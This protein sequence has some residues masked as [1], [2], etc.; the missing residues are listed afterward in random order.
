MFKVAY[1][2]ERV[3]IRQRGY[4]YLSIS[5]LVNNTLRLVPL[6]PQL[7]IVFAL[8][9]LP[10]LLRRRGHSTRQKRKDV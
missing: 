9:L 2:W 4:V 3:N 6:E 5:T 1:L 7:T 8:M 10:L